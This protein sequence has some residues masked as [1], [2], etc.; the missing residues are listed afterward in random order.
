[1]ILRK[2]SLESLN[3]SKIVD[4]RDLCCLKAFLILLVSSAMLSLYNGCSEEKIKPPVV[5]L[6][7]AQLPSQESRNDKILFTEGGKLRAILYAKHLRAFDEKR[8][9]LLDTIRIEFFNDNAQRTSVLTAR[10]G[11]VDGV[12]N[13]MY[14]IDS[15][16]A[17][18]D[19][20]TV[21][22]TQELM[23]RNNDRKIVS[24]KFVRITSPTESIQGY[25][26]VADQNLR[27]YVIYK[28]TFVTT[29]ENFADTT[30]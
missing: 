29:S 16:V 30:K 11:R 21:L 12:T 4:L 6:N 1:M 24:E 10:K 3:I 22:R 5:Q 14:A 2:R 27:N 23:W 15:V 28:P 25:G 7:E 8:E 20:G 19:S 17:A 9:T 18:N 13:N 26:V